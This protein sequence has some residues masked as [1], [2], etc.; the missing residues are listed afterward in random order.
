MAIRWAVA[1]GNW[2]DTATWNGGT[3]PTADDDVYA[4]TFQITVDQNITV[5]TLRNTTNASPAITVGGYF[6]FNDGVNVTVPNGFFASITTLLIY[7]GVGSISITG[8]LNGATSTGVWMFF[9]TNIG[10]VNIFG[11]VS[12]NNQ[13]GSGGQTIRI[14]GGVLNIVGNVLGANG[15]NGTAAAI[16][17]VNTCNINVIGNVGSS[18]GTNGVPFWITGG[19]PT[20]TINGTITKSTFQS[21]FIISTFCTINIIG[22]VINSGGFAGGSMFN[23]GTTCQINIT[24]NVK[25]SLSGGVS[26]INT[27]NAIY[28]NIVGAIETN[29]AVPVISSSNNSSIH[30]FSGPFVCS[31]YGYMP[32]YVTRMHLKNLAGSYFEFRDDSTNGALSPASIAPSIRLYSASTLADAPAQSNVRQGTVYALGSQTGTLKVPNPNQVAVGIETD[33]TVGTAA[34]TP[35]SVWNHLLANITTPN[36]IGNRLKNA[37]TVESTGDQIAAITA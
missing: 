33:N 26:V 31:S 1:N 18:S 19:T 23:I 6:V 7:D 10:T 21:I 20:I 36:S 15:V 27:A 37:S 13:T 16:S 12:G 22:N 25:S 30:I 17:A 4:N 3:L 5:L 34:L 28:L 35:E 29:L 32:I 8:S 14:T 24:G 11:N 9:K 2:S